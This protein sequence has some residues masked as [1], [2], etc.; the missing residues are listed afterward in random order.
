MKDLASAETEFRTLD[1]GR[2]YL[3]IRHDVLRGVTPRMLV[4]WFSNLE[5]DIELDGRVWPRY[6]IWHPIDH[7][8]IR[9]VRRRPDGS[10]G[11]GAQLH[12]R[13]VFGGNPDYLVDIVSTIEKLDETGF[14]HGPSLLGTQMARLE[15]RFTPVQAGTLY[16]NSITIG[17]RLT[18][19]RGLFNT[20]IRPRVFSD[21]KARAW[22]K[23]NVEEVGN[24]QYFLPGLYALARRE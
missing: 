12:I 14:V 22:L 1:D 19:A 4:W 17:P 23:H 24:L 2:L 11:P 13:E 6:Q 18:A 16:E 8:S 5:G 7:V 10:V 20:L 21:D 9:Y 15:Y 3:R